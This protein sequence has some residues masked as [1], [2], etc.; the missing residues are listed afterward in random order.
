MQTHNPGTMKNT[1][2]RRAICMVVYSN[3]EFDARVR[4][5]AETLVRHGFEVLCLTP[6]NGS[7]TQSFELRGVQV[8]ELGVPKYRGKK[9]TAYIASYLWFLIYSSLFC[10]GLLFRRKIDVVHVHNLPDFLVFSALL[11]KLAGK[12]VILDVHDSVP[13]TFASKFTG[14][15]SLLFKLLAIEEKICTRVADRVI[16]VNHPQADTLIKRGLP[17]DKV[18]VSMNMADPAVF[19]P[20]GIRSPQP[21]EAF[22][23]VYHGTMAKRLGVDL[24]IQVLPLLSEIDRTELHLWGAGDDLG[25]FQEQALKLGVT[26]K[27][28]W[29]TTGVPL[30]ELPARLACM[31]IGVIGNRRNCATE[32]MLPVKLLEYV[33][34]GIPVVAPRLRAIEHYFTDDMISYYEPDVV[35]SMAQAILRLHGDPDL[36]RKQAGTARKFL[37]DYTWERQ[38]PELVRLYHSLMER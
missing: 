14:S 13:E 10:A 21:K 18:F 36:R 34:L 16:C 22:R 20:N 38:G 12:P 3:Y 33:A 23:L 26:D 19:V 1:N 25:E 2:G 31:D 30:T 6:R 4:R 9:V 37:L 24:L 7:P 11:P 32:L 27:V 5:E 8:R 35:E 29:E 15:S 28:H 17:A